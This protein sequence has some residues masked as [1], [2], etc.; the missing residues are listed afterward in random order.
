MPQETTAPGFARIAADR[1][2]EALERHLSAVE[3]RSSE[4]DPEVQRAYRELRAA[5]ADYDLALYTEH[6][7]VTPFDLPDPEPPAEDDELTL[8]RLSVVARW[9]FS[10]DDED[11]LLAAGKRA[12]GEDVDDVAIALAGLVAAVGHNRLADAAASVGLHAHGH[13][14]WLLPTDDADPDDDDPAWMDDAFE[15]VDP[16]RVLC[17]LDS[18]V[19]D[20]DE[21]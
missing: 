11:V 20:A 13:T 21:D 1:L 3:A 7:E 4:H 8:D 2:R 16:A 6:D 12:I 19:D 5:A 10:V 14:T 15:V 18:P 9:D 17:R